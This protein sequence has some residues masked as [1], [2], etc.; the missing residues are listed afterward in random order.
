[1]KSKNNIVIFLLMAVL[2]KNNFL[3]NYL[4][5]KSYTGGRGNYRNVTEINN[6]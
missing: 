6:C 3:E 4:W 2:K 5:N 1:M